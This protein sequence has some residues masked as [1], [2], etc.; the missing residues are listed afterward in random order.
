MW[1]EERRGQQQWAVAARQA[2][3]PPLICWLGVGAVVG[4]AGWFNKSLNAELTELFTQSKLDVL[5][6]Y[7]LERTKKEINSLMLHALWL[8]LELS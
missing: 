8:D 3:R 4:R 7:E 1:R 5:L 6:K 2:N